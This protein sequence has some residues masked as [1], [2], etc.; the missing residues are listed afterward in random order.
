M[1][2]GTTTGSRLAT[3]GQHSRFRAWEVVMIARRESRNNGL[4]A[5]IICVQARVWV[6][7][8]QTIHEHVVRS[9]RFPHLALSSEMRRVSGWAS[10]CFFFL[11]PLPVRRA[12]GQA[13]A[14]V[15]SFFLSSIF[16]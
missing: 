3:M 9:G 5:K 6:E 2:N 4:V 12:N 14:C 16:L 13:S 11:S 7:F 8:R 10:T 15:S 1:D